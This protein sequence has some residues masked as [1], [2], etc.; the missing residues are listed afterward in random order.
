VLR[1][2]GV[3]YVVLDGVREPVRVRFSFLDDTH[4]ADLAAGYAPPQFGAEP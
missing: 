3:G 2:P 4:V 1:R